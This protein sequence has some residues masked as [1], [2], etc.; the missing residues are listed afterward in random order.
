MNIIHIKNKRRC[1]YNWQ[2]CESLRKLIIAQNSIDHPWTQQPIRIQFQERG[3]E[4]MSI[5]K[6]ALFKS[7][8][9]H[10]YSHDGISKIPSNIYLY[11]HHFPI[12][13]L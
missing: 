10:L 3:I 8:K 9:Q 7:L 2:E 1:H 4:K 12:E 5:N 6:Y 13:L 11:P